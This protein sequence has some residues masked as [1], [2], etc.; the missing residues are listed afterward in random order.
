VSESRLPVLLDQL[1]AARGPADPVPS[2]DGWRLVL[3]ENIGYLVD[4]ERRWQA[5]A[6][7]ELL[8]GLAPE[9]I[10][11]AEDAALRAVV[12]GMS[13]AQRVARLRRCAELAIAGASWT[14]YPG[15]GR[16]GAERI[17]LF[18]GARA[19]LALDANCLR[20]LT[21]LGYSSPGRSYAASYRQA[22][23]AA[24]AE[25]PATAPAL[26]RAHQLL[27]RHGRETCTRKHPACGQCPLAES[28]PSA[29]RAVPLY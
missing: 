5:V 21:R 11:T 22:Q 23:A 14:A 25:L 4:D 24:S 15:I 6:E 16:P 13:P 2:T 26:V 9:S 12:V 29:G 27:R 3:A 8:V 7:L 17:E 28:C 1:E 18:T 19:V 20:V 10:L